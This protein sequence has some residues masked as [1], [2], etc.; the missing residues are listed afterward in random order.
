[1]LPINGPAWQAM[2]LSRNRNWGHP[3]LTAFLERFAAE[4]KEK[5]GW[6]GLL[7]GDMSQPRGGPMLTG[8]KSH[9]IG[10]D[11]DIW[12]M[13]MPP[14]ELSREERETLVP[15]QLAGERDTAVIAAN[16]Q[17]AYVTLLK[18]A[19]TAPEVERILVHPAVKKALCEGAGDDKGWL[20]RVRPIYGHNYHFH[21]RLACPKGV[22][23][24]VPQPPPPAGDGCGKQLDDWLK[25]VSRPPKPTP[26]PKPGVIVKRRK[27][28]TIADL[29]K[30]CRALLAE[31][32]PRLLDD[33]APVIAEVPLPERRP[34]LLA[35][36]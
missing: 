28:L 18:R 8:H 23:G 32:T 34:I 7:I 22:A 9:Q 10:L 26:P 29:P 15:L 5:D 3:A 30:D 31:G 1:M 16:W 21:V 27:P 6:P 11:A 25:L 20:S 17:P 19:A 4:V 12:Y 33:A 24:C 13:P 35:Q 14:A 36:P 2:R